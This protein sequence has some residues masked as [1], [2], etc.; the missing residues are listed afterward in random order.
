MTQVSYKFDIEDNELCHDVEMRIGFPFIIGN[1]IKLVWFKENWAEDITTHVY[2]VYYSDT[3]L[4][5]EISRYREKF[6]WRYHRSRIFCNMIF[7]LSVFLFA[8]FFILHFIGI[9]VNNK[10]VFDSTI[11]LL[12]GISGGIALLFHYLGNLKTKIY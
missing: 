10:D 6:N 9:I 1:I 2:K 4:K 12:L 5:N 11:L 3:D 7:G 8:L